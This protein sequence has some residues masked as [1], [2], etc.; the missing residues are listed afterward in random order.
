MNV[1]E[2][3]KLEL[4]TRWLADI[5]HKP[6][7]TGI[8]LIEAIDRAGVSDEAAD[9]MIFTLGHMA[10]ELNAEAAEMVDFVSQRAA[11]N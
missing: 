1:H 3:A 2:Q 9:A 5:G 6:E 8:Q 7:W 11:N 4:G 10:N